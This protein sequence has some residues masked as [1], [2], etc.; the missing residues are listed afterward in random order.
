MFD[1][2]RLTLYPPMIPSLH[3]FPLMMTMCC[4]GFTN[5]CQLWQNTH[6]YGYLATNQASRL[7]PN[8]STR[9]ASWRYS[10][11]DKLQ[12]YCV[13]GR[14]FCA[15]HQQRSNTT[16]FTP[17]SASLLHSAESRAS[18]KTSSHPVYF[19]QTGSD[20]KAP[21]GWMVHHSQVHVPPSLR[22]SLLLSGQTLSSDT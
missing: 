15:A 11:V 6:Y 4:R 8:T 2:F 22:P 1:H 13:R 5:I 9:L 21:Q 14:R 10:R 3:S 18:G 20:S 17:H 16:G 19:S 7:V 12:L